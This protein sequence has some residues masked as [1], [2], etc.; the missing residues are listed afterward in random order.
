MKLPH[1]KTV[2]LSVVGLFVVIGI[3][4]S[5]QLMSNP[6][7]K[8]S[9]AVKEGKYTEA[10]SLYNKKIKGDIKKENEINDKLKNQIQDIFINYK[11]ETFDYDESVLS[12]EN[13]K[14]TKLLVKEAD[15]VLKEIK[16]CI[17]QESH[18]KKV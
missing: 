11:N 6:V 10:V 13:I 1:K 12:L 16:A 15:R 14:K 7:N 9:N 18:I 3:I 8:F 2:I 17:Y 4:L 5:I